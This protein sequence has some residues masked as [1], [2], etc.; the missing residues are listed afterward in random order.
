MQYNVLHVKNI[1]QILNCSQKTPDS[2]Q[3]RSTW[4]RT[5]TPAEGLAE[6][7]SSLQMTDAVPVTMGNA[8]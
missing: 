3:D 7:L 5:K 8:E 6:L 1:L 2:V 4:K